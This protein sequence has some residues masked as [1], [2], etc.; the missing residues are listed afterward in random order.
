MSHY[1]IWYLS[2][3]VSPFAKTGGLGDVTGAYPKAL[4]AQN[5]EVRVIMPKYKSINERKY[6]LR[7]VI[8]LRDIPVTLNGVTRIVNVKSAF[9]P[10]SKVQIYF[11]D[12]PEFFSRSGLY[13]ESASGKDFADNAERFAY[14]CK[15]ALETLKILSWRP[16]IIHCNDWQTALV[17]YYLNTIYK[18]DEFLKGIKTVFTIHNFSYQGV[19]KKSTAPA[20]EIENTGVE[21]GGDFEYF[22]QLNLMKGAIKYSDWVT[23][24]S[25]S[26]AKEISTK[27]EFGYG[28]EK[29]LQKKKKSFT[30]ILNGVDYSV[31][32]PESD[33]LLPYKYSAADM[34]GKEQNKQALLTRVNL[35][36]EENMPLIGMISRI[37]EQKGYKL[38]LSALEEL[39]ALNVQIVILGTGDKKLE[40]QIQSYQKKYTNRI[41]LNQAFDETLAHMI[42]AGSDLFLMPSSYEPCGMNQMYSLKYGTIPIVYNVGGLGETIHEY[43]SEDKSGNGLVFEKYTVKDL[44]RAVKRALKIYKKKEQ[45]HEL[46]LSVMQQ[47]FS[48]NKSTEKY[49]EIYTNLMNA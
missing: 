19:F 42:E 27:K 2:S 11:I 6:V 48:W 37:V 44:V 26:Y 47:D 30:G 36:Y 34:S 7:E 9:L 3:E 10:D 31:W 17:P 18:E 28:L 12:I 21:K 46:Q 8:R 22:D 43:N 13:T 29:D 35:T 39:M 14:F 24:V 49:L 32:S 5:Q 20:I 16:D 4:K 25:E 45:W 40:K 23:T 41:S 15:G 1:K 38:L 33:K